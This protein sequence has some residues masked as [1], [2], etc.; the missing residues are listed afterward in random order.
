MD[1]TTM[2]IVATLASL[3]C[4]LGIWVWAY[5]RRNQARFEEAARL[6]F[7]QE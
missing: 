7:E 5:S 2:R 1:I 4:F 6:P 3:A